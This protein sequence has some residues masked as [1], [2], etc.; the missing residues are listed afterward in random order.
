MTDAPAF[1]LALADHAA[2]RYTR[3]WP[4]YER[5]NYGPAEGAPPPDT[6]RVDVDDLRVEVIDGEVVLSVRVTGEAGG[7]PWA[8]ED[9]DCR[10]VLAWLVREVLNGRPD[11]L[12]DE[13]GT[14]VDL[15]RVIVGWP[16]EVRP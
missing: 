14:E 10:P 12:P 5:S 8:A 9:L 2:N 15:D 1:E 13:V 4:L 3:E 11:L 16:A 7:E 6:V